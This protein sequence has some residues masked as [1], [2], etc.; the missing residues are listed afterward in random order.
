MD[1]DFLAV[2]NLIRVLG[3][4]QE[5]ILNTLPKSQ[6]EIFNELNARQL[7]ALKWI[8]I[9]EEEGKEPFTLKL[10]AQYLS[11]KKVTAS[12]MVSALE[13]KGLVT[14]SV[15]KKDRRCI[16]IRL[17]TKGRRLRDAIWAGASLQISDML[18]DLPDKD[19]Q[20]FVR[21]AKLIYQ[22]YL[23]TLAGEA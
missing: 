2:A 14:R 3:V 7:K 8:G 19:R 16:R 15:D 23:Q 13:Q 11:M 9:R 1:D 6:N 17:A 20:H 10:L 5:L 22:N 21:I 4:R 18:D 12:L